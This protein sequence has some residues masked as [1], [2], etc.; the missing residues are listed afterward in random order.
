[1]TAQVTVLVVDDEDEILDLLQDY[2]SAEG[3]RVICARRGSEAIALLQ[4]QQIDCL[5]LDVMMPDMPGF[6]V[7]RRARETSDLPILFLSARQDDTAKL[8]GLGLGADDYIVKTS[9]P[10]EVVARV[11]AVLRRYHRGAAPDATQITRGHLTLNLTAREVLVHGQP[12]SFTPKEFELL[13]LFV[14]HPRQVFTREQI[15]DR[16]WDGYRDPQAANGLVT[17][18]RSKIEPDPQKPSCIVTVWGVGYRF[19]G[20]TNS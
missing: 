18:I 13:H 15:A 17:R 19:E 10:A 8:R 6:D 1:M 3:Y 5:V 4:T 20:G 12:V 9:S 7:C 11:K 14:E 2:L 16:L